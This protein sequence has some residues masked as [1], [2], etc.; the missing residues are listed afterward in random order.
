LFHFI[1]YAILM[2]NGQFEIV[3]VI[4]QNNYRSPED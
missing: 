4:R 2:E 1:L 3:K